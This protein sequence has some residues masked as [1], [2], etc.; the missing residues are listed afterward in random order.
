MNYALDALWW[1][2]THPAVRDLATLLTAP[3]LWH[4]GAE[5]SVRELLGERGFRFLL[6]LDAEPQPLESFLA[7][8]APFGRRLGLYAEE[9]LAFWF[10]HAPHTQ[11]LA[12]N[13]QVVSDGLTIGAADFVA[14]LNSKSYHI[15]LT[16]KYYGCTD[17]R[18]EN[19]RGLS[20]TDRLTA[21]A[22]KLPQQLMLLK[23]PDGRRTVQQHGLPA[24]LQPASIVRGMAFL[25]PNAP[26]PDAPLNPIAWR[27]AYVRDWSKHTFTPEKRYHPLDR[28]A[29]L[30]PARLSEA[31]TLDAEAVQAAVQHGLVAELERRP[32]GFWHETARLMKVSDGL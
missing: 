4:S 29:Y 14:V 10:S 17:G 12:H 21:K 8:R 1:K 26:A 30:A 20:R 32:D 11:L 23:F 5:L 13:L 22:A 18:T 25:P 16:C 2:L 15:E 31:E 27:G 3:P 24:D 6:A 19:L 9:L 7:E 28:M